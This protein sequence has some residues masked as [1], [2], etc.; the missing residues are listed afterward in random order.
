M[1]AENC[2]GKKERERK[3]GGKKEG[4]KEGRKIEGQGPR[5]TEERNKER[6]Q[7]TTERI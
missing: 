2:E 5:G 1:D 7:K 6:K 3:R 4:K